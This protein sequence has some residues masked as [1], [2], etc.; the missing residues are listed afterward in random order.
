MLSPRV[1]VPL[2]AKAVLKPIAA[3]RQPALPAPEK[4]VDQTRLVPQVAPHIVPQAV[5]ELN[6]HPDEATHVASAKPSAASASTPAPGTQSVSADDLRQ[7]RL[8]LAIAARRFK[9]YPALARERG[10]EGTVEV[11]ISLI[12]RLPMPQI[13]LAS[14]SGRSV[15]DEQALEMLAQAART[16]A[17]PESLKGRDL[18]LLLPVKFSLEFES[19]D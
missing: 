11:M 4:T 2:L 16:T 12:A 8:S 13:A 7:Y 3:I 1:T 14:S 9:R 18:R 10:W 6:A 5:P 15:L 19:T 17:L